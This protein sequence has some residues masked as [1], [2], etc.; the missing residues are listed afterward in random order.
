MI[1]KHRSNTHLDIFQHIVARL[2]FY[3]ILLS[4]STGQTANQIVFDGRNGDTMN[5]LIETTKSFRSRLRTSHLFL[6]YLAEYSQFYGLFDESDDFVDR[7]LEID[8]IFG[9]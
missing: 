4:Q 3:Q 5:H 7:L 1:D 8:L 9:F 2:V 6:D